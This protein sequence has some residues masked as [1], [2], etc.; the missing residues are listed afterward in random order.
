MIEKVERRLAGWQ[1]KL[2]SRGRR[3]VLFKSILAA[4]PIF[5]LLVYKLPIGVGKRLEG[6]M[7]RFLW[8]GSGTKQL[9]GQALVSWEVVCR[10]T[11][12]RG[13]GS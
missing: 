12:A 6:L 11:Q 13:L 2:L 1:A 7:R 10:P 9:N 3:L 4:I 5:Y 8:N